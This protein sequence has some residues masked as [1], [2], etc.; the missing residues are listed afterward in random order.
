MLYLASASP[1][2]MELM[3]Y[4]PWKV[5]P[6]AS[7]ACEVT[8]GDPETLVRENARR[9]A[10]S[11]AERHPRDTVLGADT[12]VYLP[13]GQ[14]ILG[15]PAD[16]AEAREMLRALSGKLHRVY[17]GVCV[18]SPGHEDVRCD[19]ADV[20]FD[21]L[22]D[23]QIDAY[24]STGEPLDKAGAYAI[25]GRAGVF[26]RRVEGC[27]GCVIGLPVPLVS[28]MLREDPGMRAEAEKPVSGSTD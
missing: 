19:C 5:I 11:V 26:V 9:K 25:Q 23:E 15:K 12:V 18:I 1:R 27:P 21:D 28:R 13:E 20:W 6:E 10:L 3:S 24:I 4:T 17:T 7:D 14:R 8:H 2:R 16:A 22:T